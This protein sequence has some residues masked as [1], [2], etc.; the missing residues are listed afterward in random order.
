MRET[1]KYTLFI[2]YW[3]ENTEGLVGDRDVSALN[4]RSLRT[5][6]RGLGWTGVLPTFGRWSQQENNHKV[7]KKEQE[8]G[9]RQ[10]GK[11]NVEENFKK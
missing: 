5:V 8:E 6:K 4:V 11:D 7:S 9:T 1:A 3:N 10:M 2:K